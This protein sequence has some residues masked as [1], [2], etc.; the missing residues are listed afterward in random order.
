MTNHLGHIITKVPSFKTVVSGKTGDHEPDWSKAP[1]KG[2]R[3]KDGTVVWENSGDLVGH[4]ATCRRNLT[5]AEFASIQAGLV[6]LDP[7]VVAHAQKRLREVV[8]EYL[9]THFAWPTKR[10]VRDALDGEGLDADAIPLSGF[11]SVGVGHERHRDSAAPCRR[12]HPG[13]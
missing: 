2:D 3:L 1:N 6:A 9:K 8:W 10:Q 5:D 12:G 4:C 11:R 7:G 13:R